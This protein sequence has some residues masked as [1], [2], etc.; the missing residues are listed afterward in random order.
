MGDRFDVSVNLL[1][2]AVLTWPESG[3]VWP[4][5]DSKPVVRSRRVPDFPYRLVYLVQAD[6]LVVVAL[7]HEK[8]KR[9]H[10]AA[11]S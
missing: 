7:A 11:T 6:E 4:G 3:P 2:D 9:N 5:W 10:R 8:R 1:I